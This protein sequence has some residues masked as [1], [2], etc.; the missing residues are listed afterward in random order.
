MRK[1]IFNKDNEL[2]INRNLLENSNINIWW[3]D[4]LIWFNES[5]FKFS[6]KTIQ[7]WDLDSKL[8]A[9]FITYF[10][11]SIVIA[12]KQKIRPRLYIVSWL[13]MA[14]KWNAENE[15]QKK[16][17]MIN[18]NIKFDFIR[19]FFEKFYPES[20]SLIEFV[21]SQDPIKVSEEKL[22]E[23]WNLIEKNNKDDIYKIK[24]QLAKFKKPK[25]FSNINN[26]SNEALCFLESQNIEL[27]NAFKYSI[28]HLFAFWDINFEWNYIHNPI[29][30]LSIWW[31]HEKTFNKIR[32]LSF[33]VLKNY[34]WLFFWRKIIIKDN[35]KLV[36]ENDINVPPSYNWYYSK[37]TKKGLKLDEVT[38][39][40]T[41][42]LDFYDNHKKLKPEMDYMYNN[43]I[44]NEEYLIFW[45]W[46]KKRYLELKKRYREAYKLEE[47]F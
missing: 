12:K 37:A 10:L 32:K 45:N 2:I 11:P 28:S 29:W 3:R 44:P 30:Y 41:R 27:I 16:I 5:A 26:L 14:L 43:F 34:G 40:N 22:L 4:I 33:E 7:Y 21:V 25:L 13:N 42:N 47:D 9:R 6:N 46:Y 35:L 39:E 17:M 23:L 38:Y 24:I 20:F 18:N 15:K 19:T 31:T 1:Q 8:S 36:L